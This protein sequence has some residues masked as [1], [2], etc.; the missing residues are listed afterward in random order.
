MMRAIEESGYGKRKYGR[1]ENM[2]KKMIWLILTG[3]ML[4][5]CAG[6]SASAQEAP[7]QQ[8]AVA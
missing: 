8:K 1:Q 5:I 2:F 4:A 6:C 3:M 7:D